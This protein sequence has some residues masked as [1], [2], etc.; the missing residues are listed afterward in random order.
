MR[1]RHQ[2]FA[3]ILVLVAV[4]ALFSIA[5]F[6][7]SL[8]RTTSIEVAATHTHDAAYRDARSAAVLAL[9]GLY[10]ID[11]DATLG[12]GGSGSGG[13]GD[14]AA[15]EAEDALDLPEA[16]RILLEES[17]ALDELEKKIEEAKER[18]EA[19]VAAEGAGGLGGRVPGGV[20]IEALK[21]GGLPTAPVTV[22][23]H[24]NTYRIHLTD[25]TGRFDINRADE[26]S[27]NRF[28]VAHRLNER[29]AAEITDQV[30]D[31]RDED[32]FVRSNGAESDVYERSGVTPRNGPIRSPEE[33][34]FLPGMT[35]DLYEQLHHDITLAGDGLIHINSASREVLMSLPGITRELAD[36]I[37][38]TRRAKPFTEEDIEKF[39]PIAARDARG[40]L[41]AAPSTYI[42]LRIEQLE[43]GR[44]EPVFTFDGVAAFSQRGLAGLGIRRH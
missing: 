27:L 23:V 12:S 30:L 29:K 11:P 5:M 43:E 14:D 38:N 34:L 15:P 9:A 20:S 4:A 35:H 44:S 18:D 24:D 1:V 37:V 17:G 10:T 13:G 32:D 21:I 7:G 39:L 28:L 42:R 3:L 31:W 8:S 41:R 6:A 19:N 26:A 36:N 2:G 33:L 16:I 40:F 25:A 22:T